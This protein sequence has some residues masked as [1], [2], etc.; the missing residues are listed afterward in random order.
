M[1]YTGTKHPDRLILAISGRLTFADATQFP[2]VVAR[3]RDC[4]LRIV[5]F[6]LG[7]LEFM[8]SSGMGLLLTAYDVAHG[9]G[10]QMLVRNA[11]GSVLAGLERAQFDRLMT[12]I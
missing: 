2:E 12:L 11:H 3:I 10:M 9:A 4:G 8:D 6:E 5:E 1:N 7:R